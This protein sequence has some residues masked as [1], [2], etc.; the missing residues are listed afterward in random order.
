MLGVVD[1]AGAMAISE[2]FGG[3]CILDSVGGVAVG[4]PFN[5]WCAQ[6]RRLALMWFVLSVYSSRLV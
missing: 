6:M 2:L 3:L 1:F 4:L 5:V